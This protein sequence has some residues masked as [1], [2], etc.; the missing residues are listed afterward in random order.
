MTA[1]G[2]VSTT[3][4]WTTGPWRMHTQYP[5]LMRHLIV[6]RV[7]NGL[8]TWPEVGILAVEMDEESK[9]LTAFTMAPL[10]FYECERM[11]F[12]LTNAPPLSIDWWRLVLWDL[13]LH[14][15]IIYLDDIFIFSKDPASHLE[16]IEAVFQKLEEAGLKLKPSK[17][18]LLQWQIAYF[19]HVISAQE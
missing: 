14:W 11:P 18:Q 16:R 8:L 13:N 12:R 1:W 15:C 17:C 2:S 5:T 3:E 10:D 9:P 7:L 4:S 19:R 6:H